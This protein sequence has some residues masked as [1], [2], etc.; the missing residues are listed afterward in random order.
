MRIEEYVKNSLP[1]AVAASYE[2]IW[3]DLNLRLREEKCSFLQA[4]ILIALFFES[5]EPRESVT[6]SQL[7]GS[8]GASRGN[9]S[10]SLSLLER[11]RLLRRE[12]SASDARS[13]RLS[14][15]P[16]GKNLAC[17]LVGVLDRVER[18]FEQAWS[19]KGAVLRTVAEVRS[20]GETYRAASRLNK[21]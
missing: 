2:A 19:E 11:R 3:S 15:L 9:V 4:L 6:P 10:H 17:R 14:L 21:K 8:L 5:R 12:L 20:I 13:Y 16:E 7:A 18:L 1:L